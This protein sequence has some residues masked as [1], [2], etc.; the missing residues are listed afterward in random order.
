MEG[1]AA[2]PVR[3]RVLLPN[4]AR[5][6]IS[7]PASLAPLGY[8]QGSSDKVLYEAIKVTSHLL[9]SFP[10]LGESR[11]VTQEPHAKG[12][13]SARG[14]KRKK[15]SPIYSSSPQGFTARTSVLTQLALLAISASR[16]LDYGPSFSSQG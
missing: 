8:Q 3:S 5:Q 11:E 1:R 2:R 12:D 16:Q 4:A 10:N 13:A 6:A 14:E 9:P 15:S 7:N